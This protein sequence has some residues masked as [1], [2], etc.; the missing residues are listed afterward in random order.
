MPRMTQQPNC[1]QKSLYAV[2]N[3]PRVNI[4]SYVALATC[5]SWFVSA[6]TQQ[7]EFKKKE[8]RRGGG[9]GDCGRLSVTEHTLTSSV[10]CHCLTVLSLLII[11]LVKCKVRSR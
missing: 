10:M 6:K 4:L 9:G 7:F 1:K 11:I 2:V 8:E 5:E 3:C